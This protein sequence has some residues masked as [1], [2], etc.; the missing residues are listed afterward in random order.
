MTKTCYEKT[1]PGSI[2]PANG[3]IHTLRLS[4]HMWFFW[5]FY[6]ITCRKE[7]K[8]I[9]WSIKSNILQTIASMSMSMSP[10]QFQAHGPV[11]WLMGMG[12]GFL[13]VKIFYSLS[14]LSWNSREKQIDILYSCI[15]FYLFI[16]LLQNCPKKFYSYNV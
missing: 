1:L 10:F 11:F 2:G 13:E 5:F 9:A 7:R 12:W 15:R 8:V 3:V 4:M 14:H 16:Y 6:S